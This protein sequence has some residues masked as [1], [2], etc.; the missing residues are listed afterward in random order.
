MVIEY[1]P[2]LP[3]SKDLKLASLAAKKPQLTPFQELINKMPS[4]QELLEK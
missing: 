1:E 2:D 3:D 4:I